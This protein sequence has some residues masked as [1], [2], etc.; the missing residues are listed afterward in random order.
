[1]RQIA[2]RTFSKMPINSPRKTHA[3][4]LRAQLGSAAT[5][6]KLALVDRCAALISLCE[7]CESEAETYG[8][9]RDEKAY[10]AKVKLLQ[11]CLISLGLSLSPR[12]A[13]ARVDGS[14]SHASLLDD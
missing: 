14:D 1:M 9:M 10:L 12:T 8:K 11:N 13:P 6:A 3:E 2:P 5:A 4:A 7:A